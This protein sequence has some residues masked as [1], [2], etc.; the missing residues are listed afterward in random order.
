MKLCE[1]GD[2]NRTSIFVPGLRDIMWVPN[3]N[4]VVY[5]SFPPGEN[6]MPRVTFIEMPSRRIIDMHTVNGSTDLKMFYH[7]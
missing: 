5:T 6:V 4:W 1:D 7:P 2:G 3:R